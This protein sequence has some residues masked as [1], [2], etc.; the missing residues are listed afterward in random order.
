MLNP[1]FRNICVGADFKQ[2]SGNDRT[3]ELRSC[4]RFIIT[5]YGDSILNIYYY[6]IG[7]EFDKNRSYLIKLGHGRTEQ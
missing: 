2:Y 6:N 3:I 4:K 5:G 7:N 1:F